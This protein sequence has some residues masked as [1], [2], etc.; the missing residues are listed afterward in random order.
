MEQNTKAAAAAA[1]W[2]AERLEKG[3]K[4]KFISILAPKV[5]AALD[6]RGACRLEVDYDPRGLLLDTIREM[7]IECRGVMFS[8]KGIF[9]QKH[10]LIVTPTKLEPKEGYGNW[11][12]DIPI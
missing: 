12:A 2:W 7:G 1:S 3:D 10:E 6:V 8:A 5:K 4:G 11:T 9:P